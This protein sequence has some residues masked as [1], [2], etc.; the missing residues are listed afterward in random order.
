MS[1]LQIRLF[2]K[3]TVERGTESLKG[4]DAS[5]ERE[6]LSYILV[7]RNQSHPRETLASLLWGETTTEKSKKY[8]RQ[9]LWHVQ[10]ALESSESE[11]K[12]L[13]MVEHDWV[14]LNPQSGL[15]LDVEVFERAFT[16]TQGVPGDQLDKCSATLLTEAVDLYKG[17]LLDGWYQDWCLFERERLQNMYLSMLNKLMSYCEVTGN[18][19]AGQSYGATI[20]RYDRA[21]ERTYRRLMKLQYQAKDRT[22]ALRQYE[23]CVAA[24]DEELGVKPEKRTTELYELIRNDAAK[25]VPSAGGP[26][27]SDQAVA[28]TEVLGRLKRVQVVLAALQRRVQ[29]DVKAVEDTMRH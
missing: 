22:G 26:R 27:E 17:D 8:L 18:Y 19:E 28:L 2:G 16:A 12:Q 23:R 15:W 6:L 3:F 10:A 4:L 21:S 9:A 14:Q 29:R 20:L 11:R 25:P 7:N 1:K 24:L 5:K 13:L